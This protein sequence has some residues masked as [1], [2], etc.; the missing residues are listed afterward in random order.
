MPEEELEHNRQ[1]QTVDTAFRRYREDDYYASKD[2]DLSDI[3]VPLLSIANWGGILLHFRGNVVGWMNAGSELKYLR[4]ITGRHDLPFYYEDEVEMQKS[5]LDAFLKDNDRVGWSVKG[6]LPPVSMAIRKG[7]MGYNN[8][9]AERAYQRRS[10]SE[11]PIRRTIYTKL[12]MHP[13][14]TLQTS[15]PPRFRKAQ[16]PTKLSEL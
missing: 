4:F 1:N 10:E 14:S 7:D 5:F 6:K 3:K 8:A 2:F 9:Q 15:I 13:D 16:S 11:W 12:F